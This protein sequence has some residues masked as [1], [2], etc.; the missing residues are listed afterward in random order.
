[1]RQR[2]PR[3][4]STA[5]KKARQ[6]KFIS[7]PPR[8]NNGLERVPQDNENGNE[9]RD[10]CQTSHLFYLV[11]KFFP[12]RSHKQAAVDWFRLIH[13]G[14]KRDRF[15]VRTSAH[16]NAPCPLGFKYQQLCASV[17][18]AVET[19]HRIAGFSIPRSFRRPCKTRAFTALIEVPRSSA[20]SS[21]DRS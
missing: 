19:P 1:M 2:T 3:Q 6:E 5:V 16:H 4:P 20:V 7:H 13:Q 12:N 11:F 18:P 8:Q 15:L 14:G 17:G 10:N 21:A 9:S